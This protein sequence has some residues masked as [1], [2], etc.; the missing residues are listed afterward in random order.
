MQLR[1]PI[2][3]HTLSHHLQYNAWKYAVLVVVS[4]FLWDIIY[5]TTAYRPPQDKRIDLYIQSSTADSD[6]MDRVFEE[7][8]AQAL[9]ELEVINTAF[10][11]G[12]GGQADMVTAQQLMTYTMAQ[13]GDLYF[14]RSE[15]YKQYA[16][17]GVFLDL[18]PVIAQGRLDAHD[19]D[20]TSG[21]V[22]TQQY[23]ESAKQMVTTSTRRLY[24]IPAANLPGFASELNIDHR[25]LFLAV[26]VYN[27][28]DENVLRFLDKL[29]ARMRT[30]DSK[31]VP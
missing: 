25:D 3:K 31:E 30:T 2:N 22:A 21:Y 12:G 1:T 10:L 19:I 13:E 23:D 4:I 18:E 17:Q 29:I 5:T 15:D 24:G 20:L 14:L 8:R 9:P 28:N 26:T 11:F 16:A 6:R 7:I 27:D